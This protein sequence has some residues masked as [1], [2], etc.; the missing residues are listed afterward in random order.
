MPASNV[1]LSFP[2]RHDFEGTRYKLHVQQAYESLG[3]RLDTFPLNLRKWDI[4]FDGIAI[5]LDEQLHFNRYRLATMECSLYEEL[6]LFPLD[7][8]REYATQHEAACIRASS[9]G[10]KWSNPSCERQFGT[11]G[12]YG[13]L[14]GP[15]APR[16]KQRAFYDFVKD[17][18][19]LTI[20]TAVVR[21]SVWD[22]I[23]VGG[24]RFTVGD[25][26]DR[27]D[28]REEARAQL[29]ELINQRR[30]GAV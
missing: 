25:I 12:P 4:V 15:G 13:D 14:S 23:E 21:L 24:M 8:Y 11:P 17:L 2:Q 27:W 1:R 30:A 16:W 28:Q 10:G 5:E 18:S 29:L 9:Y 19:P 26:L 3:G 22:E 6:P 20:G 7:L